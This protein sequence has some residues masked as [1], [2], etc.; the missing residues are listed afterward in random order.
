MTD[1]RV[2]ELRVNKL[3]PGTRDAFAERFDGQ[4]GPMLERHGI[5]VIH[6]GPSLAD[7]D[8]FCLIRAFGSIEE[9]RAALDAFYGSKEWLEHHDAVVMAMIDSYNSCLVPDDV[10]S[11]RC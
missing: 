8:G 6:F 11:S 4:I 7:P 2:I 10:F 1:Q 9:R 3:K 5:S